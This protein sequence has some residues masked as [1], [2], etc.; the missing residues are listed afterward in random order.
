MHTLLLS[1]VI[2][3]QLYFTILSNHPHEMI[4]DKRGFVKY[5]INNNL[6]PLLTEDEKESAP[7]M[8]LYPAKNKK[9]KRTVEIKKRK[10]QK[11]KAGKKKATAKYITCLKFLLT[12]KGA[13]LDAGINPPR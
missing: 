9:K 2:S 1:K 8:Y 13:C 6:L 10:A 5:E 7:L 12:Y 4:K 3:Q 11:K